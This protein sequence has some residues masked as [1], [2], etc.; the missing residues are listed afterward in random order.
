MSL[1]ALEVL[2]FERPVLQVLDQ[3]L[4]PG[5]ERWLA[6]RNLDE[7]TEAIGSLRVRG[8]PLLGLCGAAGVALAAEVDAGEAN[9]RMA[10]ERVGAVRPTA[11][12]LASAA[13]ACLRAVLAVPEM[14]RAA[15]AW[16]FC[17]GY[18]ER[19][20]AEDLALASNGVAVMPRG[21]VLT[22]CNTG[23]LATGGVGTALGVIR[24]A[25][26]VGRIERC[27]VTETRP[28]LQGARLTTWELIRSGIPAVLLP[29][30]AAAALLFSG[31]VAA[32]VTG[33]DRIAS[34]GDTANKVGTLGLALAAARAGVPFFVA[35]PTSTIDPGCASGGEIPIE[36]RAPD[37]VGG[38]GG[39][40]WA[41]SGIAVWNPAFDVTPGELITGII[42]E[43]GVVEPPYGERLAAFA[44]R[45]R[46]EGVH[47]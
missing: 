12:E 18:L 24:V 15:A 45:G 16:D 39:Q 8:A 28:L 36:F 4:L 44:E 7:L 20:R 43:L 38:F 3:S 47:G 21:D 34:N 41:P 11:V 37:E 23:S 14:G 19:R 13:A 5:K 27:Y 2:R 42:T 17:A 31:A 9:L 40:R 6:I 32:V 33:A 25:F 10:A 35:A 22:H 1:A 29:D 30:S 26:E 46:W